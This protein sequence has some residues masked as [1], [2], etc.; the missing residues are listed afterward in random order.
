MLKIFPKSLYLFMQEKNAIMIPFKDVKTGNW[1]LVNDEGQQEQ[2]VVSGLNADEGQI[3]VTVAGG[4]E[5]YFEVKDVFPI[6]LTDGLLLNDLGFQKEI[7]PEG[8]VKYMHGPF[9]LVI[10]KPGDFSHSKIWYREDKR[11]ITYPLHVHQLQNHYLEM[12][13]VELTES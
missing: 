1:V 3:G 2:G 9:R 5:A 13:K 11:Q 6:P 8:Y 10:E 4:N 12:T 7:L